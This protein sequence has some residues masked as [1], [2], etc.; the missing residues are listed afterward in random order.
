M[1]TAGMELGKWISNNS[2][3]TEQWKKENFDVYPI[4]ETANGHKSN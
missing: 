3:L 1:E 4:D 2:N